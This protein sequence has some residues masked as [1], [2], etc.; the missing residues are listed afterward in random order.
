MKSKRTNR[1]A[2]LIFIGPAFFFY[3]MFWIIPTL[4]AI[5][6]SF[7]RW[8][9]ISRAHIKW[10]GF[11]NYFKLLNDRFFFTALQNI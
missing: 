5:W 2:H 7:T 3:T 8:N 9:G 4:V 1:F 11:A 10:A 6:I